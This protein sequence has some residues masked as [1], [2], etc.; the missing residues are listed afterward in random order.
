MAET[1]NP[2]GFEIDGQ[3]YEVPTLDS[4][5]MDEAQLLYDLS[6]VILEDFIPA[7]LDASDEEKAA[8]YQLQ[9]V[10]IRNPAF[11]RAFVHVAYRRKHE[12]YDFDALDKGIGKMNATDI[13]IAVL[14]RGDDPDP[15]TSSPSKLEQS[16]NENA[17]S[18]PSSSGNGSGSDSERPEL[19]LAPTGTSPSVTSSTSPPTLRS[20]AS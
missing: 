16:S 17:T 12:G 18:E 2:I 14:S 7:P 20:S 11:R 19:T 3:V 8:H 15:S 6:G 10:R 4:F 13:S 1:Q 9:L 5:D